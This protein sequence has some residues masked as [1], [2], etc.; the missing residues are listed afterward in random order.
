MGD[1]KELH[2][3][4]SNEE[5]I[6]EKNKLLIPLYVELKNKISNY[7][8]DEFKDEIR[9]SSLEIE[10]ITEDKGL[11]PEEIVDHVNRAKNAS[12][13]KIKE[14]Q[15]DLLTEQ[16]KIQSLKKKIHALLSIFT[17]WKEY[18]NVI[19]LTS[20]QVIKNQNDKNN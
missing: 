19:G 12:E 8:R 6:R 5:I 18:T 3:V 10:K 9:R 4:S 13:A 15:E 11:T 16:G 2:L 17:T 14:L 7:K 1:F 20:A